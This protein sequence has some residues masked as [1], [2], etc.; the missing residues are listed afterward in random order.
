MHSISS[1]NFSAYFLGFETRWVYKKNVFS[2][3]LCS[4]NFTVYRDVQTL[5]FYFGRYRLRK[6]NKR[7]FQ[8]EITKPSKSKSYYTGITANISWEKRSLCIL[9]TFRKYP[10]FAVLNRMWVWQSLLLPSW[11]EVLSKNMLTKK[12]KN[13]ILKNIK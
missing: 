2:E 1:G 12:L 6:L 11:S 4:I 10:L 5:T 9:C 13:I 8:Y 7:K 3:P